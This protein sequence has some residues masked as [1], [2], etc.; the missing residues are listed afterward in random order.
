[1]VFIDRQP[2][3]LAADSVVEDD[4][5][6]ARIAVTHLV[7]HGHRRIAFVGD[8]LTVPTTQRRLQRLPGRF[9]GRRHRRGPVA[10]LVGHR[11]ATGHPPPS[12]PLLELANPPTAIF[13]SNARCSLQVVPQMHAIG[14]TDVALISFGDFPM[15]DTLTPSVTVID[16]NPNGMGS[17]AANRLFQRVD[18]PGKR[19]RRH[20]V[21]PVS[22]VPRGSCGSLRR[23]PRACTCRPMHCTAPPHD[24]C[25]PRKPRVG[26][27]VVR[28]G[29]GA[30]RNNRAGWVPAGS[31]GP[32]QRTVRIVQKSDDRLRSVR[33][34]YGM[35]K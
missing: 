10:D 31:S 16:Q 32:G 7:Q 14:R 30:V 29:R 17:F 34:A 33:Y 11:C 1:M 15:A 20:T 13:S 2:H 28:V 9:G 8:M 3:K 5:G 27:Q 25:R 6:G 21:L 4:F 18:A 19:L 22:L 26:R 23:L 12:P 24:E 35:V